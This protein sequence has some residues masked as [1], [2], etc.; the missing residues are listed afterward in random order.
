MNEDN[1]IKKC[2]QD[3]YKHGVAGGKT[4]GLSLLHLELLKNGLGADEKFLEI[5][6]KLR[7]EF[8]EELDFLTIK[9]NK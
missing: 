4:L 7:D 3:S 6:N 8:T 5:L 1:A 9:E 2:I